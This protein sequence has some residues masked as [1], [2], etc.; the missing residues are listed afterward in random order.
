ML[1][2]EN[3]V[4]DKDLERG[5]ESF[6]PEAEVKQHFLKLPQMGSPRNPTAKESRDV[7]QKQIFSNWCSIC[8]E[9][10]SIGERVSWSRNNKCPH[11]FHQVCLVDYWLHARNG[12]LC[13]C[14]RQD[15]LEE[16]VKAGERMQAINTELDDSTTTT[17]R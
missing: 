14:C 16:E 12:A 8:F 15:F 13:P 7:T 9:G 6:G 4:D 3:F 1:R 17:T 11:A 5:C 2:E 10:F